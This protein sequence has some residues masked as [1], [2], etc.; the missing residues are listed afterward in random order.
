MTDPITEYNQAIS[1]MSHQ[2]RVDN[3]ETAR[4]AD[5]AALVQLGLGH[6]LDADTF[7]AVANIQKHLQEAGGT[8]GFHDPSVSRYFQQME[9]VL[10]TER[11]SLIFGDRY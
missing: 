8:K 3:T 9:D 7:D 5:L 10:G 11:Y 1:R 4:L 6:P 2:D